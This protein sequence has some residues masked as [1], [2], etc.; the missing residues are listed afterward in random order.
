MKQFFLPTAAGTLLLSLALT[1]CGKKP[2]ACFTIEK[3]IPSSKINET[4]EV[5]AGCSTE[6]TSFVWEW[7]DGASDTGIK[8][9]HKYN[10][11]GTF[12]I[13]LTAKN[14]DNSA[15]TT[16]QVTIVQ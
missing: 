11:A 8:T 9:N 16:K 10:A 6:A 14:D 13:K 1:G 4:V 12:T 7:G 15:T 3:G 2:E 5:N